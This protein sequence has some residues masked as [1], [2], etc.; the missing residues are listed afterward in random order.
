[1]T[2]LKDQGACFKCISII[3]ILD[4]EGKS[5][6]AS[7][8]TTSTEAIQSSQ[9]DSSTMTSAAKL[10]KAFNQSSSRVADESNTSLTNSQKE[11][12]E[13]GIPGSQIMQASDYKL[14]E[15]AVP[16]KS[17]VMENAPMDT[18]L[19]PLPTILPEDLVV[20]DNG[21]EGFA[22]DSMDDHISESAAIPST[23]NFTPRAAEMHA[24][25][26]SRRCSINFEAPSH[27]HRDG[28]SSS[29]GWVKVR[30][31]EVDQLISEAM[32][33][34]EYLPRV[35][36]PHY[37]SCVRRVP[38]LERKLGETR[39]EKGELRQQCQNLRRKC[40]VV[41][42]DLEEGRKELFAAKVLFL[43]LGFEEE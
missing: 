17:T 38:L 4:Q 14:D 22:A 41:M 27:R 43:F 31:S 26:Q 23:G 15:T 6:V 19:D 40:D 10:S 9:W 32:T 24:A 28:H 33:L 42:A 37:I 20:S 30:A 36:N 21:L 11:T 3:N 5:E 29:S 7:T 1:M 18:S 16:H 39:R 34:K 8:P 12:K 25:T 13:N 2:S 35:V